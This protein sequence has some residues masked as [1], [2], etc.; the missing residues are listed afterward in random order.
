MTLWGWELSRSDGFCLHRDGNLELW[1]KDF[2]S[3][4]EHVQITQLPVVHGSRQFRPSPPSLWQPKPRL[5]ISGWTP[6][7]RLPSLRSHPSC[8]DQG[9]NEWAMWSPSQRQEQR[10]REVRNQPP[11][12]R[13]PP[14]LLVAADNCLQLSQHLVGFWRERGNACL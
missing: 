1:D 7:Q 6:I 13:P 14:F 11:F 2:T 8:S 4:Q 10:V 12:P 3:V 5:A 9:G